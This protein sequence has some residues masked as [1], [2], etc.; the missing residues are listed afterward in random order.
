MVNGNVQ[1]ISLEDHNVNSNAKKV[2]N[3]STEENENAN[4]KT[5]K[6]NSFPVGF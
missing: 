3:Q 2:T 1:M 4:A 5:T 6:V